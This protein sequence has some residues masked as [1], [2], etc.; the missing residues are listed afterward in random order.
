MEI[1]IC[2]GGAHNSFL[3]KNLKANFET[4][5]VETTSNLGIEPD[6]V[7]A[8]AFAWMAKQT[9]QGIKLETK[10]FTGARKSCVLGGIYHGN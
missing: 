5:S 4:I 1:Y 7:E 2:G 8:A 3:M 6:W 10:P 9:T